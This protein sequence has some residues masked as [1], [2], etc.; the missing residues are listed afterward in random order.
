MVKMA[1]KGYSLHC[2]GSCDY[3]GGGHHV[4]SRGGGGEA[5]VGLCAVRSSR[6]S[7]LGR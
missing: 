1:L 5:W 2:Q 3:G 7:P 4:H 6:L